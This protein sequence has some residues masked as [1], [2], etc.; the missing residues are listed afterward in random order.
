M[1]G[2]QRVQ[3]EVQARAQST[4]M[5]NI[6]SLLSINLGP[7]HFSSSL[8]AVAWMRPHRHL[9]SAAGEVGVAPDFAEMSDEA[10]MGLAASETAAEAP[11]AFTEMLDRHGGRIYRYACSHLGTGPDAEDALSEI[12]CRAWSVRRKYSSKRALLPWLF[13][14]ARRVCW[15]IIHQ[16]SRRGKIPPSRVHEVPEAQS[17]PAFTSEKAEMTERLLNAL[18]SL[19]KFHR[20]I[21]ILRYLECLGESEAAEILDLPLGTARSRLSRAIKALRDLLRPNRPNR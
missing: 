7:V 21:V 2:T 10:L 18:A 12:F 11:E 16:R 4:S 15:E 1:C 8:T 19:P 5:H 17:D 3:A 20:D 13:G 14:I 9:S 6:E